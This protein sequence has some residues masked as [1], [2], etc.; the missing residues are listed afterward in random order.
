MPWKEYFPY[1]P[2]LNQDKIASFVLDIAKEQGIGI[3]EAPYGI[4]KSIAML[5]AALATGKKVVF[6]TCNK[7]A[8][9]ALADEVL[10]INEKLDKNLRVASL[11]G[12]EGLCG[13][14]NSFS[15]DYC[16]YLRKNNECDYYTECFSKQKSDDGEKKFSQKANLLIQSIEK[17]IIKEPKKLMGAS[18]A[19][20]VRER[21]L[22]AGMCPY[23]ITVGL[24]RRAEVVI[25]DY[26]HIFSSIFAVAKNKMGLNPK[27]CVLFVDEADELKNRIL[28]I[29]TKQMSLLGLLRLREQ[30]RKINGI[31]EEEIKLIGSFTDS[32]TEFFRSK[33]EKGVFDVNKEDFLKYLDKEFGNVD[34]LIIKLEKVILKVSEESEKISSKPNI[35]LEAWQ[36][37]D[38]KYF[39][40]GIKELNKE[41]LAIAPYELK[42]ITILRDRE[43][44][45]LM[46]DILN[47][48]HASF[49]FSA[50]IGN[51]EIFKENLG[52]E[53]A[54]F[55]ASHEFNTNNFKVLLKKDISS[56]Y[57]QRKE[58]A[59]RVARDILFCKSQV[60]GLLVAFPSYASSLDILPLINAKNIDDVKECKEGIYYVILG[61]R[62][63][64]GINKAH[65]LEMVYVYGIQIPKPD[66]YFFVKRRDFLIKKYGEEKAYRIIYSNTMSKTCQV[67]GRIFRTKNK[68]GLVIFADSRYK[69]DFRLK[70]FFYE[71]FPEYFK[72]KIIETNTENE[73]KLEVSNFW[74]K[75][76]F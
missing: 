24:I 3:I 28:S 16:E 20:H 5:S 41:A 4:G 52:I 19:K 57:S 9:N 12:K 46:K 15:Y 18:L 58:N 49:L 17:E 61:G 70:S 7:A 68:K 13:F 21:A 35:F 44:E 55:Y 75:L 30:V 48:F 50:T 72:R 45:Y 33:K 63:S 22:D 53:N 40:Y 65:N 1:D 36:N 62:G 66:D 59:L 56:I 10:R 32:F 2:R 43:G 69:Y 31:T 38:E 37:Q 74:G 64:R 34:E 54:K 67:A 26:F 39:S 71:S 11:V 51:H 6:V 8:H 47:S 14:E 73:F 76:A 60:S 27:D 42:D 29:L 25:L 23:E